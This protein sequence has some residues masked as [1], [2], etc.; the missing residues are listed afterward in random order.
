[1]TIVREMLRKVLGGCRELPDD[2][3]TVATVISEQLR[4]FLS[5]TER[6]DKETWW[7]NGKYKRIQRKFW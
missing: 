3:V 4:S 7:W 6:T 5:S 2:C 1:M